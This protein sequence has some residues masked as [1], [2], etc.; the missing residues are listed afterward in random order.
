MFNKDILIIQIGI[1][2]N[3]IF[4]YNNLNDKYIRGVQHQI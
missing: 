3:S 1:N 2:G 4:E